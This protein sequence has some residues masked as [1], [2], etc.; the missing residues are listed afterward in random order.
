[1]TTTIPLTYGVAF[2]D[3]DAAIEELRRLGADRLVRACCCIKHSLENSSADKVPAR[4]AVD[5]LAESLREYSTE[6]K[7][8]PLRQGLQ[9]TN[10]GAG[11]TVV[12]IQ[13]GELLSLQLFTITIEAEADD[14]V[15]MLVLG[16]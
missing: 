3:L 5:C 6:A 8:G 4:Q 14:R 10:H 15:H 12:E 11:V 7:P 9:V 1:M 16:L 2:R 13:A